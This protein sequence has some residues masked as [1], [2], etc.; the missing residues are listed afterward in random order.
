MGQY[1]VIVNIDDLERIH[2][3]RLGDGLKMMEFGCSSAGTMSA[4]GLLLEDDGRWAGKRIAIIGDYTEPDDL[5]SVPNVQRLYE[6][7]EDFEPTDDYYAGW[8]AEELPVDI[9]SIAQQ[10]LVNRGIW[11]SLPPDGT[12]S[13]SV[14][15]A[16][17]N[18]VPTGGEGIIANLDK[19]QA[20]DPAAF[21]D[22]R[23]SGAFI[24]PDQPA[25]STMTA[26]V[27]LLAIS[28]NRGGGDFHGD[29]P[30]LGTWAGDRIA[31]VPFPPSESPFTDISPALF[32]AL[33]D[34]GEGKYDVAD[35][36][37]VT[38]LGWS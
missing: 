16:N 37:S 30:L 33:V 14:S 12:P 24:N 26:L 10:A 38:R 20:L 11:T 32:E 19:M 28:H 22:S 3:H 8:K 17:D 9:S 13:W 18:Y 15:Q 1:H 36:G 6:S 2:P 25:G 21:G 29:S 4:L 23:V 31:I 34:A 27:L 35:D 7:R 5:P